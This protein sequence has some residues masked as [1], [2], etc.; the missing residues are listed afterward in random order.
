MPRRRCG[1][2][3]SLITI[4]QHD[5]KYQHEDTDFLCSKECIVK[6][7]Q[8]F[9]TGLY[10]N[11]DVKYDTASVLDVYLTAT[12]Y[13]KK[14]NAYFR[15]RYELAF[16]EFLNSSS[17]LFSYEPYSFNLGGY[18]CYTPDFYIKPPYDCFIETKGIFGIG[19]KK[20]LRTF[21]EQYPDI[22]F[23]FIPWTLREEF[24]SA[25]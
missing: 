14:F 13:S 24:N 21:L 23:I 6:K 11:P 15:S 8:S 19:G 18:K 17:F 22:N 10:V 7:I 12:I 4:P 20:K 16:A 25:N 9:D 1:V 3:G 2:C 5:W